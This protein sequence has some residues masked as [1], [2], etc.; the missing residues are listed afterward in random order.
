[1]KPTSIIFLLI[2]LVVILVGW[3]ICNSAEATAAADGIQIFDSAVGADKNAVS[4]INFDP[5]EIY[6][7][8]DLV[9][10]DADVYISGGY[11]EPYMELVNFR[12]GSYRHTTANRNITV[13]TTIDLSSIIRFWESGFSFRGLRN[14]LHRTDTNGQ[15][16]KR[17]NVYLPTDGDVN[18][19]NVK[20]GSGSVY[21][22]NFDT[23]VDINVNIGE[24]DV[25]VSTF[26]TTSTFVAEIDSGSI[27]L[28][29]VKVGKLEAMLPE[30]DITAEGF[31]FGDINISGSNTNVSL[32]IVP[33]TPDFSMNLSTR[34]GNVTLFGERR[35][36][37]Y[38]HEAAGSSLRAMITISSGDILINYGAERKPMFS[39]GEETGAATDTATGTD[40]AAEPN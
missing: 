25:T 29:D 7:K 18:I 11:S 33:D 30:G 9:A 3:I 2:S 15:A 22:S 21:I 34:R 12:D 27:Y 36:G 31:E 35:G 4:K 23:S 19:I 38:S 28:R 10:D 16:T 13:D 39:G 37:S 24:G 17:I 14:Y 32:D 40:T 6:N 26:A 8:I 5:E 20:L 1:M